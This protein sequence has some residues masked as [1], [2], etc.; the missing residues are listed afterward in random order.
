MSTALG[1]GGLVRPSARALSQISE[2]GREV[3]VK[4]W[5]TRWVDAS[6]NGAELGR[7]GTGKS[8]LSRVPDA[9]HDN[10]IR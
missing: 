9:L 10:L 6:K 2:T 8:V 5:L 3:R 7:T 1:S 4:V